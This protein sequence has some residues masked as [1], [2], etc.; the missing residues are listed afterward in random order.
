MTTNNKFYIAPQI[1]RVSLATA[2]LCVGSDYVGDDA[3][4]QKK[5]WEED[6]EDVEIDG[7][8]ASFWVI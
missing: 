2:G 6:D 7:A 4:T 3:W 1:R 8:P 5:G